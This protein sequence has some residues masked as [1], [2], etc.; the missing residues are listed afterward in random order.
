MKCLTET[1][2]ALVEMTRVKVEKAV[3]NICASK[4]IDPNIKVKI[5]SKYPSE[6]R[7]TTIME[8]TCNYHGTV[9]HRYYSLNHIEMIIDRL[10]TTDGEI[11]DD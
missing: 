6:V 2:K 3:A 8:Y 4:N 7:I 5:K 11:I 10:L 1:E 9:W